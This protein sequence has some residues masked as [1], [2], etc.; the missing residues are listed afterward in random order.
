MAPASLL[1]P[2]PFAST[3]CV[4]R[5]VQILKIPQRLSDNCSSYGFT[6][7]LHA[8]KGTIRKQIAEFLCLVPQNGR[9]WIN[10]TQIN[11]VGDPGR[12]A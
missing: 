8:P 11:I 3:E 4:E 5:Q 1:V 7:H 2:C 6:L 9:C 12:K 10:L